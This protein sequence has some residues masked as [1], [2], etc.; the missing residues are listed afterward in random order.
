MS[1]FF[2]C[3]EII[4]QT[5]SSPQAGLDCRLRQRGKRFERY[6]D[7]LLVSLACEGVFRVMCAFNHRH[8]EDEGPKRAMTSKCVPEVGAGDG[9]VVLGPGAGLSVALGISTHAV[10]SRWGNQHAPNE[11]QVLGLH[12]VS[13]IF[14]YVSTCAGGTYIPR[15]PYEYNPCEADQENQ[16]ECEAMPIVVRRWLAIGSAAG[17]RKAIK[18]RA[19]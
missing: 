4:T 14:Q 7:V 8:A 15:S 6:V 10:M 1:V 11:E 16:N 18:T 13:I 9:S 17:M 12:R 5:S 2:L 3:R 19:T